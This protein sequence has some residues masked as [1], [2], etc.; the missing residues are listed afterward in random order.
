MKN[1]ECSRTILKILLISVYGL[2]L[3]GL[4]ERLSE[5]AFELFAK[6]YTIEGLKEMLS[7][8]NFGLKLVSCT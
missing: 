5:N 1:G 4:A 8:E 7:P 3:M 2:W 6:S